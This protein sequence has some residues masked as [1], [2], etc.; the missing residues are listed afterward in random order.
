MPPSFRSY[1][2]LLRLAALFAAAVVVF[3]ALRW[4]LVPADYGLQG[5]YRLGAIAQNQAQPISYAGQVACVECH[6]DVADTRTGNAHEKVACES[7]HG[8]LASHAADP[9]VA[10]QRP[11][12]RATCAICH[13]PN[14]GKPTGFKTV[15]FADHAD[16]GPCTACHPAHAPRTW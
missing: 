15:V 4:A 10:A 16:E 1:E 5:A 8:P 6:T 12:P 7:C 9:S 11:D 3:L 2:H 13:V 14:A